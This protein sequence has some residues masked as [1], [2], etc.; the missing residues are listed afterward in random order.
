[1]HIPPW[2][3]SRGG[4]WL[5]RRPWCTPRHRSLQPSSHA[6]PRATTYSS[7]RENPCQEVVCPPGQSL[8]RFI[9]VVV[10]DGEDNNSPGSYGRTIALVHVTDIFAIT[11]RLARNRTA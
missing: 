4:R 5:N 7:T 9:S 2:D 1:M 6:P 3:W 8:G 11:L 10:S